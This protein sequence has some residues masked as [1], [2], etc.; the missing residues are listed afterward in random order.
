MYMSRPQNFDSRSLRI[1]TYLTQSVSLNGSTGGIRSVSA[2]VAPRPFQRI[3]TG[4]E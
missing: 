3:V 1:R 4:F 2:S